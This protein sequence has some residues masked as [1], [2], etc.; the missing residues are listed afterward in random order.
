MK[1]ET[2]LELGLS[3]EQIDAV[4]GEYGKSIT[5]YKERLSTAEKERDGF[6]SQ[7]EGQQSK[8]E[9]EFAE[10]SKEFAI[11]QTINSSLALDKELV[12]GLLDREQISIEGNEI[13]GLEEQLKGIAENRPFLFKSEESSDD[14]LDGFTRVDNNLKDG[15]ISAKQD[16]F[17]N[18]KEKYQ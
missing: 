12:M 11:T 2:L 1:R 17:S 7:F 6:K 8:L 3:K 4:L 9:K 15:D 18:I 14:V 13:K 5:E 10:K 16:A